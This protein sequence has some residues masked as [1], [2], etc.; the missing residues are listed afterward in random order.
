MQAGGRDVITL[1]R[2]AQDLKLRKRVFLECPSVFS[3]CSSLQLTEPWE[4][5]HGQ[6]AALQRCHHCRRGQWWMPQ[7][8]TP[9]WP[10]RAYDRV[11]GFLTGVCLEQVAITF[12]N[13]LESLSCLLGESLPEPSGDGP[14]W[15]QEA[16]RTCI[17]LLLLRSPGHPEKGM[18]WFLWSHKEGPA[19]HYVGD[20][21]QSAPCPPARTAWARCCTESR[22]AN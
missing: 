10:D 15:I 12:H 2:V 3:D 17:H 1:L 22:R 4:P 20:T 8:P 11:L 14:G 5:Y 18:V 19:S 13:L 21:L 6:G 16:K 7:S 9:G